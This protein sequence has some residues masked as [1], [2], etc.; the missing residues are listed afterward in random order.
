MPFIPFGPPDIGEEEVRAAAEA[1]RSG[2]LTTGPAAA[3]F[4]TE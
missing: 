1:I 2:W 4:E 3:A